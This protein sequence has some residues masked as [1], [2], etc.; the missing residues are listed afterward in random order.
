M[1]LYHLGR[2]MFMGAS[3]PIGGL[4]KLVAASAVLVT[5][6]MAAQNPAPATR[7][8]APNNPELEQIY[9]ED[10]AER[11]S[12]VK[13]GPDAAQRDRERLRRTAA[14][15][16]AGKAQTADDYFHAAQVYNHGTTAEDYLRSHELAVLAAAKG[17]RMA[18]FLSAASLD[19][20]LREIG[21]PQVFGT[22]Y[23]RRDN[24][25]TIEP[26]DRSMSDN[27]RVEFGVPRLKELDARLAERNSSSKPK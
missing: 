19:R 7:P 22:Q 11:A 1:S 3:S 16:E 20:F 25:A 18:L 26:F 15:I 9:K 17:N 5:S 12:G 2:R 13:P 23:N 4:I 6:Q 8:V 21:R 24:L 27:L 10:Q 14:L